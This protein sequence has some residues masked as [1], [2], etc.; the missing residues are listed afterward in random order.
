MQSAECGV[1]NSKSRNP[2][3]EIDWG[4]YGPLPERTDFSGLVIWNLDL[5]LIGGFAVCR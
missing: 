3:S 5:E 2:K 4:V 1:K